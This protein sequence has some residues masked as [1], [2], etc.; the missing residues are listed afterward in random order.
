MSRK[1]D[2]KMLYVFIDGASRKNPGM[3]GAGFLVVR[4]EDGWPVLIGARPLGIMTNNKAEY[5][6]LIDVLEALGKK[7]LLNSMIKI[8]TDS[9]LIEGHI[10]HGWKVGSELKFYFDH[11]SNLLESFRFSIIWIHREKNRVA[12]F[13]SNIGVDMNEKM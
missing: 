2:D 8:H 13:L 10:V 3:S 11:V 5:Q 6:A 9:K 1:R 4:E 12:D 7:G